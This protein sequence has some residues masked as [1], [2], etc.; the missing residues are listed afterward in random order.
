[1]QAALSQ[2]RPAE[3]LNRVR[4]GGRDGHDQKRSVRLHPRRQEFRGPVGEKN[5]RTISA[6]SR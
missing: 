5:Q 6:M 1:M 3:R 4:G 2:A